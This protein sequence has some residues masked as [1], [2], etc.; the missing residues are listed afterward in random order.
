MFKNKK[1]KT[2]NIKNIII[3]NEN[4][5]DTSI[6]TRLLD[7]V[8]YPK[9]IKNFSILKLTKLASELRRELIDKISLCGGHFASS[10]GATE[11]TVALHHFYDTPHDKLIWDVGHQGYIHKLLTGR[12]NDIG[13]IRKKGHISGFLK[14]EESPFDTFASGHAGN[15]ISAGVGIAEAFKKNNNPHTVISIIGDASISSGMSFEA[16]NNAGAL[17]LDNFIVILNDNEMSISENVGAIKWILNKGS[18]S[19]IPTKLRTRIK[20]LHTKGILPTFIY[21]IFARLELAFKGII[22][23]PA[24]LFESFGFR[25]IGPVDGHNIEKLLNAFTMAKNQDSPVLLHVKTIK[26]KGF[27]EAE[28]NPTAWHACN[29]FY[30]ANGKARNIKDKLTPTYT[31]VF[32]HTVKNLIKNDKNIIAITAA[33]LTGTGLNN[34]KNKYPENVYDVGIAEEHAVT[35]AGGLA[36]EGKKPI[37]AIYST[38]MQR[39]FDQILHDIALQN[40]PVVFALDRAGVVG[41][42]GETHQ[43]AFD[44]SYLR[45]IPNMVLIAPKDGNELQDMVYSATKYNKPV[46]IRYKRGEAENTKLSENFNNIPLGKA[47]ILQRGEKV[48]IIFYGQVYDL[49]KAA[50]LRLYNETNVYPTIVN[51]RFAKPLDEKLLISEMKK[52]DIICTVEDQ[53]LIGGFGSA[54]VELASDNNLNISIKRFGIKDLFVPHGTQKEQYD[55]CGFSEDHIY[56]Y[57]QSKV[58]NFVLYKKAN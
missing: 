14:R 37:V 15:S 23:T 19:N 40:L 6:K 44:V 3:K 26:G 33:M 38:F 25:Y 57:L 18:V 41:A 16:L 4:I 58:R 2:K 51:A 43:G 27:K 55:F 53:S 17:K 54:V 48:L 42:D 34:V 39:A 30:P 20:R 1:N 22:S 13:N 21:K 46:A 29:P 36:T 32:A 11:L 35:F 50:S 28:E 52:H 10:L 49:V 12:K 24:M 7:E 8:D 31:E 45:F 47:E 5:N 9:D 56:N